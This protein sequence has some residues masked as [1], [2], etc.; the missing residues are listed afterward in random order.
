MK[1]QEEQCLKSKTYR[2]WTS[3][4]FNPVLGVALINKLDENKILDQHVLD[5]SSKIRSEFEASTFNGE[6][7]D[8]DKLE[9]IGAGAKLSCASPNNV[10]S[11]DVETPTN[12]Q[13][14][15]LEQRGVIS[16][17]KPFSLPMG[18]DA[19]LSESFPSDVLT[20]SSAGSYEKYT[21]L[22]FTAD[23]TK[24]AIRI[25]ERL[26]VR[27]IFSISIPI[28]EETLVYCLKIFIIFLNKCFSFLFVQDERFILRPELNRWLNSFETK[29][30]DRKTLDRILTKLQEQG[31]C[32]CITVHSPVISEYSRTKDCVVV[33]HPSISLS[34]ELYDEIRD[35]VRSFNKYI[36]SKSAS[37]QK[38]D[39]LIPVMD[40]IQKTQSQ[41]PGRQPDNSE[42]MRANGYILAKMIRAKLLHSFLWDYLHRSENHSDALSYNGLSDNPHSSSKLFSLDAAIKAIP[43]EL[44]LQV[45]GSTKKYEEM[46]EKCKMGLCL[47][48]LPLNEYKSLMDTL[49]TGRMS[50]VIDILRRL[51]VFL[52]I[53]KLNLRF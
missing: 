51:K 9:D 31:Q 43:V 23:G 18:S 35:K 50:L 20:P 25:L 24:R 4:N 53:F 39:E 49:A 10:E 15:A 12:L 40:D 52:L 38:S 13:E 17:S 37:N 22:S 2:V 34:P 26:K 28:S 27:V 48:D 32:K 8:P 46:I 33:V 6:L 5:S 44:F 3:R 29:T 19:A 30:M 14:S 41:V 47:S 42:A 45:V 7:V 1:V 36:R 16:H 11:N 21:N